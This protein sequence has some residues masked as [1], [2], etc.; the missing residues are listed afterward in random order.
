MFVHQY[1]VVEFFPGHKIITSL[2][3]KFKIRSFYG[4]FSFSVATKR[5]SIKITPKWAHY[6]FNVLFQIP[7][8]LLIFAK[9]RHIFSWFST[10][11]DAP[12][13]KIISFL[14]P[15]P[16]SS[17]FCV[18]WEDRIMLFWKYLQISFQKD[19]LFLVYKAINHSPLF[20]PSVHISSV[21]TQLHPQEARKIKLAYKKSTD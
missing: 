17:K 8:I 2:N 3:G 16:I 11:V 1:S 10:C 18:E 12:C 21:Q 20:V 19:Y 6:Y 13:A 9:W 4:S 14:V 15:Y 5:L 7:R